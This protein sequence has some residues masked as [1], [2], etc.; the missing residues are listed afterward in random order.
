MTEQNFIEILEER[1][2][3]Q[4]TVKRYG[5]QHFLIIE[6]GGKSNVLV[7]KNGRRKNI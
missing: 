6:H 7:R 4:L 1:R 2:Y 5:F 3:T